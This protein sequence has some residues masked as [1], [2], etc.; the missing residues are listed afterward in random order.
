MKDETIQKVIWYIQSGSS[1]RNVDNSQNLVKQFLKYAKEN[2][3]PRGY[4]TIAN[5]GILEIKRNCVSGHSSPKIVVPTKYY[6]GFVF[7]AHR[8]LDHP[9]QSQ[10]AKRI[11]ET[12]L[13]LEVLAQLYQVCL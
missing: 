5:D 11:K 9:S 10:L 7:V 2:S 12:H 8:K 13:I 4:L 6:F 1:P 3:H